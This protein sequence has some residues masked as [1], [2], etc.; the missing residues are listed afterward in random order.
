MC[1]I[2]DELDR[3]IAQHRRFLA[4]PLDA[5][6]KERVSEGLKKFSEQRASMHVSGRPTMIETPTA[7]IIP[8]HI[9][10]RENN[11]GQSKPFPETSIW[12]M[13]VENPRPQCPRCDMRMILVQRPEPA[14]HECLRCGHSA[15]TSID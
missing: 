1:D 7:S 9:P 10:E 2:C 15:P 12:D 8:F 3:K 13:G 5:L 14:R 6:T 11:M 4:E